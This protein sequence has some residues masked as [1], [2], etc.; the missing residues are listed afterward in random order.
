M[1]ELAPTGLHADED[2][3]GIEGDAVAEARDDTACQHGEICI[4]QADILLE[5]GHPAASSN[6]GARNLSI[7]DGRV[8]NGGRLRCSRRWRGR[9]Q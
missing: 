1:E 7:F 4:R 5:P 8:R 3:S 6:A 2:A 9:L